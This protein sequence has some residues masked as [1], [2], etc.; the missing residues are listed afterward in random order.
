MNRKS[1]PLKSRLNVS[2]CK[3]KYAAKL[4][5]NII[6]FSLTVEISARKEEQKKMLEVIPIYKHIGLEGDNHF[7][8]CFQEIRR[9]FYT[10]P[11][12]LHCNYQRRPEIKFKEM[13]ELAMKGFNTGDG[14]MGF[15]DGK[16][17]L[18]ASESDYYEY[19]SV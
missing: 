7:W 14:Y 17:L 15:V 3:R 16:Y 1:G 12:D 10:P 11:I 4:D 9:G 8:V 18:F 2:G 19:M 6:S 13:E 5:D